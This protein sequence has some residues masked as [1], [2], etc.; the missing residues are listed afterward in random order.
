MLKLRLKIN[1]DSLG[2]VGM[3]EAVVV[4]IVMEDHPSQQ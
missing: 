1:V 2:N 4:V 3:R